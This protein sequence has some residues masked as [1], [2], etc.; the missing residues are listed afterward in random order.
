[1]AELFKLTTEVDWQD[2]SKAIRLVPKELRYELANEFDHIAKKFLGTWRRK[3]LFGPPGVRG[4]SKRGLFG[5]FKYAHL[6][7]T[8]FGDMGVE[9]FTD[10]AIARSHEEGSVVRSKSGFGI[11]VPLRKRKFMFTATGKLKKRYKDPR[12]IKNTIEVELKGQKYIAK[13]DRTGEKL[14]PLFVIKDKVQL[15]K[16]L[17]FYG[18]WD[19]ME[20]VRIGLINKAVNKALNE[21]W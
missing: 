18:E 16:R 15:K 20:N 12:N 1:M 14:T 9:I 19:A 5:R 17:G 3:R 10:S 8:N 6:R 11:A 7:H 21:V 2:L 4:K 13:M